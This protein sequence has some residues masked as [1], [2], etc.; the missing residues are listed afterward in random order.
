MGN[1]HDK[2]RK[3]FF[4]QMSMIAG[5]TITKVLSLLNQSLAHII[6]I[7]EHKF[8]YRTQT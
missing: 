2:Y 5:S 1:K 7:N 6:I 8:V 3:D 4:L